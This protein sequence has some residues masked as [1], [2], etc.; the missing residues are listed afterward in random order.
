MDVNTDP[1]YGWAMDPDMVLRNSLGPDVTIVLF[2]S[3]SYFDGC[4]SNSPVVLEPP[5]GSRCG[6][7]SLA[8]TLP[9][10]AIGASDISDDPDCGRALDPDMALAIAQACATPWS[11]VVAHV[12]QHV[13]GSAVVEPSGTKKATGRGPDHGYQCGF[14]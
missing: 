9:L 6:P 10:M 1:S 11:C 13:V 2:D 7:R 12:T 3:V 14:W 5:H 8:S 4:G